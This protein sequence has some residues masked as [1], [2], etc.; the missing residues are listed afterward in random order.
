MDFGGDREGASGQWYVAGI[1]ESGG[2]GDRE[3]NQAQMRHEAIMTLID[4]F[5]TACTPTQPSSS[6]LHRPLPRSLRY[7]AAELLP[8]RPRERWRFGCGYPSSTLA[9][10]SSTLARSSSIC[11]CCARTC[12]SKAGSCCITIH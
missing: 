5:C 2:R 12:L 6:L 9:R 1:R 7:S 10:S 11:F 8:G 4:C 3:L